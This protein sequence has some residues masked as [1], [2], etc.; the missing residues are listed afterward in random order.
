MD[1]DKFQELVL[2][3]L[4]DI[5]KAIIRLSSPQKLNHEPGTKR[6]YKPYFDMEAMDKYCN[7]N[8]IHPAD[9]SGEE[10]KK[11]KLREREKRTFAND[12]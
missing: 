1:N 9:L 11:F 4:D 5:E 2:K 3:K 8:Y 10:M 6:T 12:Q 7:E